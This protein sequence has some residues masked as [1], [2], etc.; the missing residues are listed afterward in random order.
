MVGA[1]SNGRC[2]LL[3]KFVGGA[4]LGGRLAYLDPMDSV[5]L[6]TASMEWNVPAKYASLLQK[7]PATVPGGETFSPFF[8]AGIP[9]LMSSRSA[10]TVMDV[11]SQVSRANGK[12]AAPRV[13]CGR[14]KA[15]LGS[16]DESV[17]SC[18]SREGNVCNDASHVIGVAMGMVARSLIS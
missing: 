8:N 14:V 17:S 12:W 5:C 2:W 13:Q 1:I 3:P 16:E 4:D 15:K 7:E 10:E 18:G 6:R 11:M 9:Q